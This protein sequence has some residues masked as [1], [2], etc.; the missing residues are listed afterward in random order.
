VNITNGFSFKDLSDYTF[1]WEVLRNGTVIKRS[2]FTLGKLAAGQ[3]KEVRL[4]LPSLTAGTGNEYVLNVFALTKTATPLVPTGHEVARE[5]FILTPGTIDLARLTAA[6]NLQV[7]QEGDKITF[8]AGDVRGEF[9]KKQ[10]RLTD[11]RLRDQK[12]IDGYPEPYFWRAPTDNDFGN[13]MPQNL[14]AWRTAH[15]ARKVERVTVGEQSAAGLPIKVDYLLTAI[16]VPYT[17]DYLIGPD[18]AV[19]VTAAID[20][21]GKNLPELPR[22]GMRMD[23]PRRFNRLQ[24]YGRG[25]WENYQDRN[26]ATFLGT[27]Q[28]SVNGQFTRNYIRPQEN[29]NHTDVRWVTLTNAAGLGLRVEGQQPISFSAL[30]FRSEDLDP[31]L[32][33]KQQ[34]PTDLKLRNSVTLHVDLK[35]R[36]VGGDNSWGALPHEPYRLLDKKYAY[37]YTLRLVDEKAPQP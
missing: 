15:A 31:G 8:T 5:Q 12:I 2:A 22:F 4:A 10:G 25:P 23:L 11:Y 20:L 24:Y 36:G 14:G 13:N 17:V 3:Q 16:D 28:D 32:T 34:H 7:K 30:P 1:K 33:K 18:G 35:Q 9:D 29:G 6:G 27:Y 21:T 19:R 26:T 37:T